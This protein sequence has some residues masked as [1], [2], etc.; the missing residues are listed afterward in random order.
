MLRRACKSMRKKTKQIAIGNVLIGDENKIAVQSMTNTNTE[1][2]EATLQQ[3]KRLVESGCE[4]IRVSFPSDRS[5]GLIPEYKKMFTVPLV[6]DIHFD[7]TLAIK[8]IEA[9]VDKIRINPGNIGS[10]EKV[11]KVIHAARSHNIPIRIGVNGGSLPSNIDQNR[12]L[13][14]VTIAAIKYIEFFHNEKF[15]DIIISVK[16]SDVTTTI[17]AYQE[18]SSYC[19][20]PLHVGITEAGT[21]HY[22]IVKSSVGIGAIL[23]QGIGDTIRVSLTGDPVQ[24][25][26]VAQNILKSLGLRKFGPEIIACPTCSRTKVNLEEIALLVEEKTKRLTTPITIAVMGCA[27]N[28]PGE[29]KHADIGV[30]CG[31]G[32]GLLFRKGEIVKKVPEK[33]IV[34]ELLQLI[35]TIA[36]EYENT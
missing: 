15:Y 7:H 30:A 35:D 11:R 20:Y 21:K 4:I 33:Q 10:D 27:V 8:A 1:D 23:S 26:S 19:N 6:A 17:K 34:D 5:V 9:G 12:D 2:Y 24:E 32:E 22:G 29:A 31:Q 3:V 14:P 28:G 36:K 18:I 16:M 25:V 13:L